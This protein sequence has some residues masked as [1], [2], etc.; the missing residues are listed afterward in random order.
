MAFVWSSLFA[1][2]THAD[3]SLKAF[4]IPHPDDRSKQVEYFL[5]TPA[6]EGPWPAVLLLH[7]HQESPRPGGRDFATWGV[8]D[9]LAS[10]GYLAVAVSQP[11]YGNSTGPADFCGPFTQHAVTAVIARL[12]TDHEID[13]SR[14][15]LEGIS[16]G[17][18]VVGL[19]AA[20]DSSI[21]GIVLISGLYELPEFV[22]HASSSAARS[23]A[24][25][26]TAETGGDVNALRARSVLYVAQDIRSAALILNGAKDDRTDP[27]QARRLGEKISQHG[28]KARVI[29]Y[30][31]YGHNI[32]ADVRAKEID[33][34]IA[35]VFRK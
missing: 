15:V 28:G 17:A 2:R 29:I 9:Q 7:G 12:R 25:S 11:G 3:P 24:A 31:R 33:P 35:E 34:F 20:R 5:R 30:D 22:S 4:F 1:C 13:G 23:V 6:G 8:L 14:L 27:A 18:L 32:P 10:R 19:V 21:S 26:V 16:R